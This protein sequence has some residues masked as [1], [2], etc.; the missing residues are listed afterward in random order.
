MFG[1]RAHERGVE[2]GT[3]LGIA[4]SLSN[5]AR[6]EIVGVNPSMPGLRGHRSSFA[7]P[8]CL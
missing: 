6:D 2:R 1:R 5:D 8:R 4:Y 3:S 7:R